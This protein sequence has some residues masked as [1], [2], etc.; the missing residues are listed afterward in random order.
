[1]TNETKIWRKP[2]LHQLDQTE[3]ADV[4]LTAN[5]SSSNCGSCTSPNVPPAIR[6]C[7]SLR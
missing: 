2:E 1:M 6:V 7:P 4:I 5:A 3:L